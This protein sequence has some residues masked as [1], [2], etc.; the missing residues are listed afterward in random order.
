MSGSH[1]SIPGVH[2]RLTQFLVG[3]HPDAQL[4]LRHQIQHPVNRHSSQLPFGNGGLWLPT[5]TRLQALI[6]PV[7]F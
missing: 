6:E 4:P 2:G 1:E 7:H 3:R 5:V